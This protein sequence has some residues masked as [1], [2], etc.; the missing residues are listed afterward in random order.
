MTGPGEMKE[1]RWPVIF[2]GR[3][4]NETCGG[5][6]DISTIE[7]HRRGEHLAAANAL[8]LIHFS[9]ASFKES[10][11]QQQVASDEPPPARST[12]TRMDSDPMQNRG[13][14]I[15]DRTDDLRKMRN[16]DIKRAGPS[17]SFCLLCSQDAPFYLIT[18]G[19]EP[20]SR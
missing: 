6:R 19:I 8:R 18:R 11:K 13:T 2:L 5:V 10:E 20:K 7:K 16:N 12:A 3:Q 4:D 9:L 17:F 14:I 15:Y 1:K